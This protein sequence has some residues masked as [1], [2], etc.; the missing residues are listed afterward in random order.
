M[1]QQVQ[2]S[3]LFIYPVKS[4]AG[5]S[6]KTSEVDTMGLKYDRRWMLVSPDGNYLSQRTHPQMALVHPQLE[7]GNLI[8]ST[9]GMDDHNVPPASE[10]TKT[11]R[12]KIWDDAV[13]AIHVSEES[14]QWLTDAIGTECHLVYISDDE[15]RQCNLDYAEQGDRTGFADGFP[16]LL[17]SEAS[18]DDLNERMDIAPLPMKRFRP[19]LVVKDCKEYAEDKWKKIKIGD[20]T[21]RIVKP[22]SRCVITTVDPDT[23]MK[24]GVEPL[25]TLATYRE[26][27]GEVYFGQN[28][29]HDNTGI[30][31]IGM[32]IDIID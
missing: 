28:V 12:V 11:K 20:L 19:N 5:I 14:D 9:F 27:N 3:G 31:E 25:Q 22:C 23:G 26:K 13:E 18:L 29:I 32:D 6:L 10:S 17:I 8:L 1:A 16:L 2:L 21:F 24:I 7:N 4:L 15:I 30:L